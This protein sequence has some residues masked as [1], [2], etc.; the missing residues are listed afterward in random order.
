MTGGINRER[1]GYVWAFLLATIPFLLSVWRLVQDSLSDVPEAYLICIPLVAYFWMGF[2]LHRYSRGIPRPAGSWRWTIIVLL[3]CGFLLQ[4]RLA[5]WAKVPFGT[6]FLIFWPLW[7]AL[8]LGISYGEKA[9]TILWAP[10]LYLYLVWPP[11]YVAIING[12]NPFLERACYEILNSFARQ[13]PWVRRGRIGVYGVHYSGHWILTNVT[14]ACS[15]SDSILALLAVFPVALLVFD[16][17]V[18]RKAL[19]V[20]VGCVMAFI[21]NN[22]RIMAILWAVHGWGPYWGFDVI[23]PLL[24]P[25]IFIV[26]LM[27]LFSYGGLKVKPKKSIS[28]LRPAFMGT[29]LRRMGLGIT[30]VLLL[31]LNII[32]LK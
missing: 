2:R 14:A 6:E 5:H 26:L 19:I 1:A 11:L 8:V 25:V 10:L 24:G 16:N 21:G 9:L 12:A 28:D 13:F 30:G 27:V 4:W 22:L 3:V 29:P 31:L 23:H 18:R 15:G 20:A 17:S 32:K 7:A